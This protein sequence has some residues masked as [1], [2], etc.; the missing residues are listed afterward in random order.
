MLI[1]R[2]CSPLV[3]SEYVTNVLDLLLRCARSRKDVKLQ[4]RLD[5]LVVHHHFPG[6]KKKIKQIDNRYLQSLRRLNFPESVLY[7]FIPHEIWVGDLDTQVEAKTCQK[8]PGRPGQYLVP[9]RYFVEQIAK[10]MKRILGERKAV[11]AL[12]HLHAF[13]KRVSKE[14]WTSA[15]IKE[16]FV[17]EG[18]R[19]ASCTEI[20][21]SLT[22]SSRCGQATN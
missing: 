11:E 6:I 17:D 20:C 5:H 21:P 7:L 14:F 12:L 22:N 16:F 2:C 13:M 1:T 9:G 15:T 19:L 4:R 10:L 18:A 8:V 3:Y